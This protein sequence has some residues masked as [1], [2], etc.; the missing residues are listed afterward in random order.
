M[1]APRLTDAQIAATLRAHLPAHARG[2]LRDRIATEVAASRPLRPL[3]GVFGRL[4]DA[5]PDAR[6]RVML[7]VAA[8]LLAVGLAVAATV[9]ALVNRGRLNLPIS[10]AA[11]QDVPALVR[12]AYTAMPD[13]QPLTLTAVEDDGRTTKIYV[14][15]AGAVRIERY[16]PQRLDEPESYEIL[17]GTGK[18]HLLT[19][20]GE[21]IWY[22]QA[23]AISEDPRV[24]VYASLAGAS[25]GWNQP[26]CQTVA[27]GDGSDVE[28]VGTGYR[29]L[30][31]EAILGRP[32]HHV[33]CIG[34]MWIDDQTRLVLRSRGAAHDAEGRPIEGRT[35]TVEVVELQFGE[36]PANLFELRSPAGVRTVSDED[37][38]CATD[39]YCLASPR[40]LIRPPPAPRPGTVPTDLAALVAETQAAADRLGAYEVIVQRSGTKYPGIRSRMLHDGSGRYRDEVFGADGQSPALVTLIVPDGVYM[41]R[42]IGEDR[43]VWEVSPRHGAP[44]YPLMAFDTCEPGWAHAGVDLVAGR[45]ADH[46]RCSATGQSYWI[47]R[48]LGIL[49]RTQSAPDPRYGTSVDE[50]VEIRFDTA[51]PP[52]LFELPAGAE[53]FQPG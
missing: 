43:S 27:S 18:G 10:L 14:T 34:E 31:G 40:P 39:P 30:G 22:L 32:T 20:K 36:P 25:F 44:T 41:S 26:Q 45:T 33:Q 9:G 11:P 50:I 4:S 24:F 23:E 21:R 8:A 49:L 5:D 16:A 12:S 17:A 3:P 52:G 38:A 13:L 1:T 42:L 53:I 47:D 6:R 2:D 19:Y 48:E 46:V 51:F 15:A 37:Y 29:W 7:L 28:L 35:R